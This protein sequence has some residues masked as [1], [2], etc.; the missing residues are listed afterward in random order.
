MRK[1][2]LT[3]VLLHVLA[4]HRISL[5]CIWKYIGHEAIHEVLRVLLTSY[6]LSETN[7]LLRVA[8]G[9]GGGDRRPR[10]RGPWSRPEP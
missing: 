4:I 8:R 7:A 10:P 5:K 2:R 6:F 9:A 1:T 3:R